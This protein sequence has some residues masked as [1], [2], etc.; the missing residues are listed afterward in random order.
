MKSPIQI[1]AKQI[2]ATKQ[3]F[4]RPPVMTSCPAPD[5]PNYWPAIHVEYHCQPPH[6]TPL[7]NTQATAIGMHLGKSVAVESII[8]GQQ[9]HQILHDGEFSLYP[10]GLTRQVA[11]T[12]E[13]RFVILA[14]HQDFVARVLADL[15]KEHLDLPP[16]HQLYDSFLHE[17]SR[18][19]LEVLRSGKEYDA[20]YIESLALAMTVYLHQNFN[21]DLATPTQEPLGLSPQQLTQIRH[22][23][24]DH[25]GQPI[26]LE[27][28][29]Q[30]LDMSMY[31]FSR[32]FKQS[33]GFAPYQYV[34]KHRI[35]YAQT[36]LKSDSKLSMAE[37]STRCGFTSQSHFSRQFRKWVGD[38]PTTYRDACS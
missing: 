36:L 35:D 26:R 10:A 3:L 33:T 31:Y 32:M 24:Q 34:L 25:V 17:L 29:A 20:L 27:T 13:N 37:I 30:Q 16:R 14:L 2:G 6:I 19:F 38:N 22:Y 28:L 11:W 12:E 4:A 21:V 23:I 5:Q 9:K 15:G 7:H 1:N 18:L 8:N